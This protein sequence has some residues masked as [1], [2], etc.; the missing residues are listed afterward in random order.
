F[1]RP[2]VIAGSSSMMSTV[3]MPFPWSNLRQHEA[4]AA[5]LLERRQRDRAAVSLG[6]REREREPDP[7]ALDARL[8]RV[9]SPFELLPDTPAIASRHADSVV[10]DVDDDLLA[11]LGEDDPD[12][13]V[14][15]RRVFPGV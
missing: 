12:P 6:D 15:G 1:L 11:P 2:I 10:L 14:L 8:L 9:G 4:E 7:A 13:A 3:S 5:A